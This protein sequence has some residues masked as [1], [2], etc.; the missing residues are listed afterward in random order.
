MAGSAACRRAPAARRLSLIRA[1]G[2]PSSVMLEA[3]AIGS[4]RFVGA[5]ERGMLG[6]GLQWQASGLAGFGRDL[7]ERAAAERTVK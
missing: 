1:R 4:P 3:M 2:Q 6:N 5:S 7:L